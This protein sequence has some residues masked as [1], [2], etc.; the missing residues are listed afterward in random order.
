MKEMLLLAASSSRGAR[1][2]CLLCFD[3]VILGM[4][5]HKLSVRSTGFLFGAEIIFN[6]KII[7]FYISY[8]V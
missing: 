3:M 7:D 5:G 1:C 4:L 8:V 2:L 6:F